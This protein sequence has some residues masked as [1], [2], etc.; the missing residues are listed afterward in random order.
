MVR[1]LVGTLLLVARGQMT[2][3]EFS[4]VLQARNRSLAGPTAPAR[5][6]FLEQVFYG[7]LP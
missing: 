4:T 5:G 1:N 3:D 7:P 2:T 6:L